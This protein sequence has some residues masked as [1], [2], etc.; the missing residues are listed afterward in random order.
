M[1]KRERLQRTI[2][3]DETDRI[4][5]ALW[6]HFPG[7]D[8][9]AADLARSTVEW[10][11]TYDWDFVKVTPASSYAVA[12]YGVQDQWEGNLEGTRVNTRRAV[13]R[14]LDWTDL[15]PADPSRGSLGRMMECLRLICAE[16]GDETPIIQTIFN[17]LAQAQNIA[18]KDQLIQ[19]M[20][21]QPD[22]LHSGLNVITESILRFINALRKLPLAGIFYAVQHGSYHIMSAEEYRIF[23]LPY[24]RKI[25]EALPSNWWLNVLH[26]HGNAPMFNVAAQLPAQVVNW[27]DRSTEP[28]LAQ[29]KTMFNGAVCGGLEQWEHLHNG[30]P[31]TVLDA[32]RS[33]ME[34]TSRRRFI[35]ATGC[36]T[37]ITT[38]LSNIR[39][40][41]NAV[42]P[43]GR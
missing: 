31:S 21:T 33:A 11:R 12:D 30:T 1:N 15:R 9:R 38:P 25:M 17:P 23:G 22:R 5:V 13:S 42:E 19:H 35:L 24:D 10:Q 41:R 8:E 20:R 14:S 2:A 32:A 40:T 7:D 37:M 34:L 27:H 36:V 3:G 29:G 16:L 4:P 18:G 6:R 39:A 28:D 43:N 26:L